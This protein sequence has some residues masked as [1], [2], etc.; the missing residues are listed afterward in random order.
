MLNRWSKYLTRV[1]ESPLISS[2]FVWKSIL[3]ISSFVYNLLWTVCPKALN[4]SGHFVSAADCD[5]NRDG[6]PSCLIIANASFFF[7]AKYAGEF[8]ISLKI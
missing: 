5:I 2:L 4:N 1:A 8:R 7:R 3:S 6:K